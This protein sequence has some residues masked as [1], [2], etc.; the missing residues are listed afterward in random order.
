MQRCFG[1]QL[2]SYF[3][4]WKEE[5]S[6]FETTVSSKVKMLI[7]DSYKARLRATFTKWIAFKGAQMHVKQEFVTEE[8]QEEQQ[9][10][11]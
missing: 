4:K 2:Q 9:V 8:F 10:L 3:T 5:S 7:V 11:T 1:S 6:H